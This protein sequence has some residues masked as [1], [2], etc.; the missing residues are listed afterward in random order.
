MKSKS[1][2]KILLVLLFFIFVLSACESE[3]NMY[4]VKFINLNEQ[5]NEMTVEEGSLIEAPTIEAPENNV[6]LGWYFG[7]DKWRFNMD[8]VEGD[9]TLVAKWD[10]YQE[11]VQPVYQGMSIE[12]QETSRSKRFSNSS[13]KSDIEDVVNDYIDVITTEQVEYYAKKGEKFN[14]VVHIYNPSFYEILSFTLNGRKY[15]S[16][17]FKD[18]S[19]S[20]KLIIEVDAG[21]TPG[22]VEYT[23]DAIKYVD[24]T[25]IKDVRMDGEKT[26]RAGVQYDVIPNASIIK[27]VVT[28]TSY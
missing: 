12:K 2:K 18:G 5:V 27:E 28:T 24:E 6:L 13:E 25:E 21:M 7:D 11:K 10:K 22:I 20:T 8:T 23:I 14:V 17:E 4:T 9:M 19:N 3:K 26:I 15:Q 16:F 1:F